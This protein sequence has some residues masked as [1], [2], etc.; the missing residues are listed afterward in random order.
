MT[1]PLY[2]SEKHRG[3]VMCA[4]EK[5]FLTVS[6]EEYTG[7][8]GLPK[9]SLIAAWTDCIITPAAK[10]SASKWPYVC[11]VPFHNL[12]SSFVK[13]QV[14]WPV[15]YMHIY[16]YTERECVC[17]WMMVLRCV[18]YLVHPISWNNF[19]KLKEIPSGNFFLLVIRP[20]EYLVWVCE[21]RW[22]APSSLWTIQW[23]ASV[24]AASF[25]ELCTFRI[26]N[27][28]YLVKNK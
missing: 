25:Q 16:I 21:G 26:V 23:C 13:H 8:N 24:H 20:R 12:R 28:Q 7:T 1:L 4:I 10:G 17:I 27:E 14:L 6:C 2:W 3:R 5:L 9:N 15:Q 22:W 11:E 18:L 19:S